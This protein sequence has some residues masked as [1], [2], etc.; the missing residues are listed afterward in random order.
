MIPTRFLLHLALAGLLCA[1]LSS[2]AQDPD[3][4][5]SRSSVVG[6]AACISCHKN[7]GQTY[8]HTAHRLTSQLPAASSVLGSFR[9][10]ENVLNIVGSA[11]GAKPALRFV[12]ESRKGGFFETAE[13]EWDSQL[14]KRSERIDLIT[15]S[16]TRGQTYLYWRGDRLFELPVSYW[17][18]GRKWINSPG[19]IDGTAEFSR[20]VNPACLECHSTFIRPLSTDPNTNRYER[21]SFIPGISCET[22]HGPG[23]EHVR[24][25]STHGAA[26]SAPVDSH[27]LNP[28]KFPR[29]RKVDLCA[30]CH[31]GI[32]RTP[33]APAFSYVP[34]QPLSDYY[35]QLASSDVAHPDVHGNQVGL[36]QRSK[37]YI[38]SKTMTCSTCHDVHTAEKPAESYSARCLS[39][40]TWKSCKVSAKLG[41]KIVNDCVNCHMPI[42][43][44][45]AIVS[46]TA[47]KVVHATMRNHW[48]KIYPD[49]HSSSWKH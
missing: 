47:G 44:T 26:S 24:I 32:Q 9:D 37:C 31:N 25:E 21:S 40:H 35:K 27:I 23:A 15:G 4:S 29:D 48:I 46:Q 39:C 11:D 19:Y 30:E 43:Q 12:M 5:T 3:K 20:A 18:D 45:N 6:D 8:E 28:A 13:T 49:L 7:L 22:C 34:G 38:A 1:G 33:L 42:E 41:H 17:T 2:A 36:L 16:G 14:L 10:G